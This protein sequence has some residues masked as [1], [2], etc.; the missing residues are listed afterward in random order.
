VQKK[1]GKAM[2]ITIPNKKD[3]VVEKTARERATFLTGSLN[4]GRWNLVE[5]LFNSTWIDWMRRIIIIATYIMD[6]VFGVARISNG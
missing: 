3:E 2:L 5:R 4:V 6:H 1:C